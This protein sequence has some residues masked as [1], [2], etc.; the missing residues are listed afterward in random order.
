[1]IYLDYAAT[2]PIDPRVAAAMQEVFNAGPGN[3]SAAHAPGRAAAQRIEAARAQVAALIG[4]QPECIVF[5]SGATE[6]NNLAILGVAGAAS[7]ADATRNHF[8]S[9]RTEHKAVLDPL[10][11]LEKG[12][13]R[14][15]LLTPG[16][17]GLLDLALLRAALTPA[18]LLVTVLHANNET[19]VVQD[20]APLARLCREQGVLLHVDAAQS[21]GKLPID[22]QGLGV[23]LL[24]FT[25]HKLCGPPGVGALY[26]APSVRARLQP[27]QF[28]GGQERGLRSGSLPTHQIVGFGVACALAIQEGRAEA[29]RTAEL[30]DRLRHGLCLL[31]GVLLNGH[32][33]QRLPGIL[34]LSFEGVEGESLF[35]S[36]GELAVATGAAC[37]SASG[38]PSYVLRALGRDTQLAQSSLRFSF[39]RFST[40]MEIDG[41]ILAVNREIN[42]LRDLS[43]A[44][45]SAVADSPGGLQGEAGSARLGTWVR[46]HL[47][48]TA[49]RVVKAARFQLYGCPHTE[50][51]CAWLAPRLAGRSLADRVPGTPQ[52]WAEANAVP[53]EKLGRL[54]VIE[55]ALRACV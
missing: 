32:P 28:G 17:D 11:Q 5:T 55:D 24:S 45:P 43:P 3:A 37:N 49:D 41:A 13:A 8:V 51:V 53:R 35:A 27:L 22:V 15:T 40:K 29:L 10:R 48:V 21:A 52:E 42:R 6:A 16:N 46:W 1:M 30:R 23:D 12:G 34:N 36:L 26:V 20:L 38:E 4:A 7:N 50:A 2:T 44:E 54:L 33:T 19:G 31:P 14:V 9:L 39:G 47:A 18:T 25:A